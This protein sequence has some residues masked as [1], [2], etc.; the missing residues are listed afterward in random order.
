MPLIHRHIDIKAPVNKVFSYVM[1]PLNNLDWL[2]SMKDLNDVHGS[3]EGTK[4]KWSWK[5]CHL[6]FHGEAVI[7]KSIPD[8]FLFIKS[9][10]DIEST[11]QFQFN[12]LRDATSLDLDIEYSIPVPVLGKLAEK[13]ILKRNE[14]L[15]DM[16]LRLLRKKLEKEWSFVVA[17]KTKVKRLA[18]GN[19]YIYTDEM[20][21][22]ERLKEQN[23]IDMTVCGNGNKYPKAE[24]IHNFSKDISVSGAKIQSPVFLP[25]NTLLKLHIYLENLRQ[26]ITVKGKV[27]WLKTVFDNELYDAGVEFVNPSDEMTEKL[28]NYISLQKNLHMLYSV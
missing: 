27:K 1:S 4:F 23:E 20:R 13:M 16:G 10:G 11:W 15:T 28:A 2:H 17:I 12:A 22:A 3:G 25:V 8:K 21:R 7:L 24:V 18:A 5:M 6:I 9:W 19:E 14:R 26:I